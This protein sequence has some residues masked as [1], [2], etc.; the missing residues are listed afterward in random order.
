MKK[1]LLS[2]LLLSLLNSATKAQDLRIFYNVN[3]CD[4]PLFNATGIYL[5]ASVGVTSPSSYDEYF[6]GS[7]SGPQLPLTNGG[8]GLWSICVNPYTFTDAIGNTVPLS[9]TIFNMRLNFR[10]L[11]TT[12]FTGNCADN[13]V[14]I[15]NPMTATPTSSDPSI[16]TS[17]RNCFVSVYDIDKKANHIIISPNPVKNDSW[18]YLSLINSGDAEIEI[19]NMLGK[20]VNTIYAKNQPA[21]NHKIN[22]DAKDHDGNPLSDG[23]YFYSFKLNNEHIKTGK[24]IVVR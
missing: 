23:Y 9:A 16:V 22:F 4:S 6:G 3:A 8:S 14:Q 1:I 20:K 12:I 24:I 5:Y 19:Y 13:Y 15:T 11:N 21:G 17:I 10:D 7:T 2:F 18:F